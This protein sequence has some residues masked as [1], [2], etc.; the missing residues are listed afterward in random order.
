[1]NGSTYLREE[2]EAADDTSQKGKATGV[3][4]IPAEL[5]QARWR[6]IINVLTS[7]YNK[8]VEDRAITV[9]MDYVTNYYTPEKKTVM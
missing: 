7:I 6:L 4:N 1:M 3:D 8:T 9:H 2:L 5:V